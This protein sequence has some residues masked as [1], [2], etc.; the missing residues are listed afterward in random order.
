M[1]KLYICIF[2]LPI[3]SIAQ[4]FHF[5]PNNISLSIESWEP[6]SPWV[7]G[8]NSATPEFADI[9]GDGDFDLF[10][11]GFGEGD[12]YYFENIGDINNYYFNFIT[13]SFDS[14]T[15]TAGMID[16]IFVDLDGDSDLDL[17]MIS[18]TVDQIF[19]NVGNVAEPQYE[20]IE[21]TLFNAFEIVGVDFGDIDSDGDYD[22]IICTY[23]SEIILYINIGTPQE[24]NYSDSLILFDLPWQYDGWLKPALID[25]D[26]DHDFDLF[27]G[28]QSG[29]LWFYR[30]IGDSVNYNFVFVTDNFASA[31]VYSQCAP[32]FCDIDGDGDYDLFCGM[33]TV[34]GNA[35]KGDISFHKNIGS[36]VSYNYLK[37]TDNYI[38]FDIGQHCSPCLVDID[39]DGDLDLLPGRSGFNMPF[40]RNIGTV[41]SPAFRWEE[42]PFLFPDPGYWIYPAFGD[43]DADGDYDMVMGTGDFYNDYI[44]LY[45]NEGNPAN[46]NM[47]LSN[48]NLIGNWWILMFPYLVDIDGD[49]D[50]DL[51]VGT[52]N[53]LEGGAIHFYENIGTLEHYDFVL[54]DDS[55]Q[56]IT[57]QGELRIQFVDYDG[58]GDY[59]LFTVDSN[60]AFKYYENI[61]TP[62]NANFVLTIENFG[63]FTETRPKPYFCDIDNDGDLDL[64][65][66]QD[67]GGGIKFYR[68]MEVNSVNREP[69]T[70]NRSFTLLP[71]YPNPFNPSTTIN[72]ALDKALPVKLAVYNQLGQ[73]V[74]T[75]IDNQVIPGSY[76]VNWNASQFSSGVYLIS[77]ESNLGIQQTQKVILIK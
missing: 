29:G 62:S 23:G 35:P 55:Y 76:R 20:M 22:A 60:S 6:F 72:F 26:A 50:L 77:L 9:D 4:E 8:L 63:N 16:P 19:I 18:S 67:Y 27:I 40:I 28:Q 58:D 73:E 5:E 11:G 61:G 41:D 10:V 15:I 69:G 14:I 24:W 1:K 42:Y 17:Y 30:N 39:N 46:P 51:M 75:I 71:C 64:F 34:W 52:E 44:T 45:E 32:T 37:I 36:S 53:Y 47:I 21:D 48:S 13:F 68:N 12:I 54:E 38:C 70:V 59:D 3:L 66:G 2:I 49:G 74:S 43:L 57:G 65:A 33:E 25:I 56:G 7:G 31:S